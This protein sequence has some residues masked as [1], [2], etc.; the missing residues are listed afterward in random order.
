MLSWLIA[1]CA[2]AK[3]GTAKGLSAVT[4]M[5]SGHAAASKGAKLTSHTTKTSAK[6]LT[7]KH[8]PKASGLTVASARHSASH[9]GVLE[10]PTDLRASRRQTTR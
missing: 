4:T 8:T 7:S 10:S 1:V 3:P 6:G 2:R 9:L 5:H